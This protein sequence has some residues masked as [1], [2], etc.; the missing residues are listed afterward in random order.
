[1]NPKYRL[2]KLVGRIYFWSGP[3][4][5]NLVVQEKEYYRQMY[6]RLYWK[7]S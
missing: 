3:V 4:D 1:M 2:R 5:R 6:W 7:I